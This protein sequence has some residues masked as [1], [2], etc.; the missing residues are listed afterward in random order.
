MKMHDMTEQAYKNGYAQGYENGIR[1]ALEK[2]GQRVHTVDVASRSC[3]TCVDGGIDL[4]HC[5]ECNPANGF[6]FFRRKV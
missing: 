6:M 4:P 1:D 2:M 5:T 3:V